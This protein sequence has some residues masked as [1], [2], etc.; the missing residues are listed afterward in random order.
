[1]LFNKPGKPDSL[2]K[3]AYLLAAIILG[4]LLSLV[5]QVLIEVN[6]LSSA[7]SEGQIVYFNAGCVFS[8]TLQ[9]VF[10]VLGAVAGFLFG[11]L[12]W[13]KVYVERVWEK[14]NK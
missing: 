13:R 2:K 6:Y 3:A 7:L 12:C 9:L 1:M 14:K 8:P 10:Y 11:D 4:V 5:A